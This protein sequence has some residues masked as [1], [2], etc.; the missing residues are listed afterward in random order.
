MAISK[1]SPGRPP[2][3]ALRMPTHDAIIIAASRCFME[4]GYKGVS[5]EMVASQ[6]GITK[7]AIYYHFPDKPAL[8]I[9]VSDWI[10]SR[11][12]TQTS[13]LLASQ[14]PLKVR[15]ERVAESFFHIPDPFV[16]FAL[17]MGE[18]ST[19]LTPEQLATIRRHQDRIGQLLT[20]TFSAAVQ[21]GECSSSDP[22]FLAHAFIALLHLGSSVDFEGNKLFPDP[23]STACSLVDLFWN[24]MGSS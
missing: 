6:A 20:S 3:S 18:A 13:A 23:H 7:A 11:A 24:G 1:R 4:H 9:A 15:L 16:R 2:R 19:D 14:D 5:M 22:L 17:M 12:T 10:F 21:E 8:V